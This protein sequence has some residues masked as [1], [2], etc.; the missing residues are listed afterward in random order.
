MV[1]Y[2]MFDLLKKLIILTLHSCTSG[3]IIKNITGNLIKIN[4]E[5][6]LQNKS[7]F[8]LLKNEKCKVSKVIINNFYMTYTYEILVDRCSRSCNSK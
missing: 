6:L 3:N 2:K 5:N 1:L 7:D 8:F 4:P